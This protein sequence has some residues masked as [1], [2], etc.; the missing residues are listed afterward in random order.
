MSIARCCRCWPREFRNESFRRLAS[1]PSTGI[2]TPAVR[3]SVRST[4]SGRSRRGGRLRPQEGAE[5]SGGEG[6]R[7][8]PRRHA[9]AASSS[10]TS[11]VGALVQRPP[12]APEPRRPRRTPCTQG[13]DSRTPRAAGTARYGFGDRRGDLPRLA[14]RCVAGRGPRSLPGGPGSCRHGAARDEAGGETLVRLPRRFFLPGGQTTRRSPAARAAAGMDAGFCTG[15]LSRRPRAR[16][17]PKRPIGSI[18]YVETAYGA[19]TPFGPT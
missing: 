4:S 10:A 12:R 5:L 15:G 1:T 14:C 6:Q 17:K 2:W 13:G 16:V 7:A 8:R 3:R 9:D 18:N 11:S 19:G